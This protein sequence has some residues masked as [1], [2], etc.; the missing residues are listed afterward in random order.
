L[1]WIEGRDQTYTSFEPDVANPDVAVVVLAIR[2]SRHGFGE[3]KEFCDKYHKPLVRLPGGYNP[4][5]VAYH[6]LHQVGERL[7]GKG[8]RAAS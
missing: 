5:Q 6:I 2:W 7:A 3:V 4:N 1:I 8:D